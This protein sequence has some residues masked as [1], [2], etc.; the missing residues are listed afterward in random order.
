MKQFVFDRLVDAENICNLQREQR[1]LRAAVRQRRRVV[2][3]GPRNYG[4]TSV[5]RNVTIA[6]FRR[7]RK[8]RF[9]LFADLLGVRS[10]HSLTRRL[11]AGLQRSFAASFPAKGFLES[12]GRFLA[13]LRPEVS[14]DPQTGNPSLSLRAR[15][16][17]PGPGLETLWEHVARI[18][19]E[20]DSLIVLDE[21]QDA[22]LVPEAPARLRGCLEALGAVPVLLLGSQR[23]ML[24]DLFSTPGAPL[25]E[26][27]ADLEFKPI[28]YA[29]YRTYLQERFM[30]R[31]LT[32]SREVAVRLQDDVQRV[33]EAINRLGAQLLE[34][35]AETEIDYAMVQTA[36]V[37]LLENREGRYASY[38]AAFSDTDERV[39]TEIACLGGVE[40]PQSKTFLAG[41][42]LSSR[43]VAL[44]VKRLRDRGVIEYAA[45][46][47]RIADPLLAAY[48]RRFR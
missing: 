18:T 46:H 35:Y 21:F 17:E 45:E 31:R 28:P 37:T 4:K 38:L 12:A 43:T 32:I 11:A 20:V 26:W 2:I 13:G 8:R 34:L 19:E 16:P 6:E 39:L 14:L 33:P 40:R 29:D 36:L 24:A 10:M 15:G 42:G 7:V 44:A 41:V 27:G 30:P 9:V 25:S 47:Y 48:L 1:A 23:H 5:V 22:A 3:Y